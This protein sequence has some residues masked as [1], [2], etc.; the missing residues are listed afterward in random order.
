MEAPT[1]RQLRRAAEALLSDAGCDTPSLD[2]RLLIQHALD[3]DR[4]DL[5]FMSDKRLDPAQAATAWE[6]VE[7]RAA[8]APVS[9]IIGKRGFW[10]L[11][12]GVN[13]ATLDPRPDTETVVDAILEARPDR[14]APLRILDLGTGSG[15]I[16]LALLSEYPAATGVG[17]DLAAGAATQAAVN[18]EACEL[19]GRAS[20]MVGNWGDGLTAGAFDVIVSN[21]PYIPS[22]EI[23]T[24][25]PEVREH[26]PLQ[27]LDGGADG[28]DAYRLLA[29]Q[30]P[31]LLADGGV[32]A[33][34]VGCGQADQ[35]AELLTLAGLNVTGVRVDLGGI[36]R[37][38][39]AEKHS[40]AEMQPANV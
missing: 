26:D 38:V 21:P 18:A 25:A 12:L 4:A 8:H 2:A 30:A 29:D 9:R 17:V 35:V 14:D 33:F 23:E 7:R 22:A 37:C 36:A 27:A 32:V 16:L 6:L 40:V 19:D 24:L 20:F 31:E 13:A 5:L 39:R 34:E 3:L 1:L 11:D 15:A 10:T 28:L